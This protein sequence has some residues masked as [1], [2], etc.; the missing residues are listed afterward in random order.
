MEP[1]ASLVV[2]FIVTTG[3][4][5]VD[6][7]KIV[8][9][10]SIVT[11]SLEFNVTVVPASSAV[12]SAVIVI[13][14]SAPAVSVVVIVNAPL[15]PAVNTAVSSVSPV[16]VITFP[17]IATSSTVKAVNVPTDVI[18]LWF[19]TCIKP[20]LFKAAVEPIVRVP[21]I[22]VTDSAPAPIVTSNSPLALPSSIIRPAVL[23][24]SCSAT[25][26]VNLP[27]SSPSVLTFTCDFI[28]EKRTCS[29]AASSA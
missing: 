5:V 29:C 15:V 20:V 24:P 17:S 28:S 23:V 4:F 18:L 10:A 11:P 19:A 6:D 12:P 1:V 13:L 7:V 25:E 14:A 26:I 9:S 2:F 21:L 27:P 22:V 16:M 8:A 3:V